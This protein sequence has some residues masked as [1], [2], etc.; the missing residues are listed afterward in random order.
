LRDVLRWMRERRIRGRAEI[1]KRGSFPTATPEISYPRG[2]DAGF[3]ATWLGHST[4]LLQLGGRNVLTDPVFSQ[5][6]FPVQWAG[7]RRHMDPPLR[8]DALPPLDVVLLSHNH[9]D[10]L[11][12]PAVKAIARAHPRTTWIVPL[13]VSAYVRRW[14]VREIIELDWWQQAVIGGVHVTATPARHFSGR[15]FGDRNRSLWCGFALGVGERRAW[16]AG[17]T[18]YHPGF[19]EIATRLGPFDLVM[20]PIGA[21]DPR[22]FMRIVHVDPEEAV[23]IYRD[24]VAP[25]AGAPL[26][27][28]LGIHWGTFR[29]TDEPMDEPPRRALARWR[30]VGLDVERLWIARFGET[31]PAIRS[32]TG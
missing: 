12:K 27:L 5:R 15:G 30:A 18:A 21:Y 28:M 3:S 22:W 13:G 19:G 25:H 9:Y 31:R 24:I 17:D 20:I 26:P 10:H 16:F 2:D 6:A 7:P 8:I 23:Q 29:L 32:T 1:P 11:D 4:V 14:G